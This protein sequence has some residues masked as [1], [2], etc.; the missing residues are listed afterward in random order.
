[1]NKIT[2]TLNGSEVNGNE[3]MTILE[4][5]QENSVY[6][7]TLCHDPNLKP[8]GACRV[9]LVEDEKSGNLLAS[10][11]TPIASGMAINTASDRVLESRK[12]VVELTLAGH[13]DS[14][15]LCDK[16]NCCKLRKIASE[17]GIG[18]IEFDK[19]RHAFQIESTNP[20]IERDLSKCILCGK[21]IRACSEIE[22]IGAIDYAYRGFNSRPATL[23]DNP[24]ED[25]TCEFCGLCVA[26][27]PVGALTDKLSS[28]KGKERERIR[29]T[30]PYCGCGCSIYLNTRVQE[31]I[32][33]SAAPEY[34]VN[35]VSL[36]VKGR[37]GYDFVKNPDRLNTP[38]IK[39]DGEF[40]EATWEEA[41]EFVSGKLKEIKQKY[42]S[43][44]LAG[45]GSARCTNEEN[46][47]FQK[48]FRA[49]LGSNNIDSFEG[50]NILPVIEGLEESLGTGSAT[51]SI[52]ELED[53]DVILVI[54][55]DITESHPIIGQ[56]IKRAVR[57]KGARLIIID[58]TTIKL[59]KF[60]ELHLANRPGTDTALLNSLLHVIIKEGLWN[61]DFVSERT[62]GLEDLKAH[63]EK[64]SPEYAEE[65]TGV[66][67]DEI[68]LA[69]GLYANADKAS[70]VSGTGIT[71]H[72]N[73]KDI[74]QNLANLA[75]I[76]GN[77]GKGNSGIYHVLS[78]NN[79]QGVC[80]M[81]VIPDRLTGSQKLDD[82]SAREKFEKQ[83]NIKLPEKPGLNAIE[84]I[85]A[86]KEGKI[87]G[88][89]VLGDNL[90][91]KFPDKNYISEVLTSLDLMIVQDI[92][93]NET[94]KLADVVLPASS[95]AE[96]DGTYTNT[97]RRIQ[98]IRKALEP[99]GQSMPDCQIIASLSTK[100]GYPMNYDSPE[101]IMEEI[102]QLT[103]VY[104]G[105]SYSR[106]EKEGLQWPC[107]DKGHPGTKFLY[108]D[109]F[110]T[111]RGKFT[112][113]DYVTPKVSPDT[114]AL[115]ISTP[116]TALCNSGTGTMTRRSGGLRYLMEISEKTEVGK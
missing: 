102:A 33:V 112:V 69:A 95:F 82:N 106:L 16:G 65:I 47:L 10:C 21:C 54:G 115:S 22:E 3:G 43:E 38:L 44:S 32:S 15:I 14:C 111:G 9:C 104:G 48:F 77:V 108:E 59:D 39:K 37:Y 46:Y 68:R 86:V 84:I 55:S 18:H 52:E 20:F 60:A 49:V 73:G 56:K 66:S 97:D 25:S 24:L 30:C 8:V 1:M 99:I 100:M 72:G 57:Q 78:L 23:F 87:K 116:M 114:G 50:L 36:C 5:A 75:M 19:V 91:Q 94:T 7:P 41:L 42:G 98:R 92:F 62:E 110:V 34:S 96:K 28:Y 80:D 109:G 53:S 26:M 13:P 81:G 85:K 71:R 76:T 70:I 90:L 11:V 31:I 17:L 93:M 113:I 35:N 4:L 29:T 103:P 105:I 67:S 63:I 64:Y 40:V 88:L 2:I 89:Y 45:L 83:W 12:T 79:L 27:C 6:I 58:P 101:H 74:A 107:P 61:K 51:N